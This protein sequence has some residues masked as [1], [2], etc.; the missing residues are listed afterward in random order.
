MTLSRYE[1][2][3]TIEIFKN[4]IEFQTI[5]KKYSITLFDQQYR[6]LAETLLEYKNHIS[7]FTINELNTQ[8]PPF[9]RKEI[10]DIYNLY[11][12]EKDLYFQTIYTF[13]YATVKTFFRD[14]YRLFMPDFDYLQIQNDEKRKVFQEAFMREY[15]RFAYIIDEMYNIVDVD[16]VPDQYLNY[17]AQTVGYE[18]ED[19]K[20]LYNASFRELIKN[21]IEIY[22]IK[23]TNYSFELFFNFLGFEA[24]IK[25]FWFDK[26]FGDPNISVNPY[27]GST[28]QNSHSFYLTTIKPTE[29]IPEGMRNSYIVSNNKIKET[30]DCNEFDRLAGNGFYTYKQ[31]IGDEI[32]YPG[33]P[34]TFFKTNVMEY[35]LLNIKTS[36][37][38]DEELSAEDL[39]TIKR[40]ADFLTPIF[41]KKNIIIKINPFE[42]NAENILFL[43][44]NDRPDPRSNNRYNNDLSTTNNVNDESFLHMY[45]G[46]QPIN[47][48]WED[49][50]RLYKDPIPNNSI[51]R[52][53]GTE[54][55]PGGHFVSGNYNDT[56]EKIWNRIDGN[57]SVYDLIA[58]ENPTWNSEE[59]LSYISNLISSRQLFSKWNGITNL[60]YNVNDRD[61]M[62]PYLEGEFYY[63]WRQDNIYDD[64]NQG[65]PLMMSHSNLESG[66]SFYDGA[67]MRFS[68]NQVPFEWSESQNAAK[69]LNIIADNGDGKAEIKINDTRRRFEF[70]N[71][72]SKGTQN[73]LLQ[74]TF[75]IDSKWVENVEYIAPEWTSGTSYVVGD[76]VREIGENNVFIC[77]QNNTGELL[78]NENYWKFVRG[79]SEI[80]EFYKLY[81]PLQ[82]FEIVEI[83][84]PN[85]KFKLDRNSTISATD[86]EFVFYDFPFVY[87][88]IKD[89]N[90]FYNEGNY[91]IENIDTIRTEQII[92]GRT[93]YIGETILTLNT[94]LNSDQNFEFGFVNLYDEPW[95]MKNF[96]FDFMFNKIHISKEVIGTSMTSYLDELQYYQGNYFNNVVGEINVIEPNTFYSNNYSNY[97]F[98][99]TSQI[100][101]K[102]IN[103]NDYPITGFNDEITFNYQDGSN[104]T[105]PT[106]LETINEIELNE[107]HFGAY[108]NLYKSYET[109]WN[110]EYTFYDNEF[111]IAGLYNDGSEYDK[112]TYKFLEENSN[113]FRDYLEINT[114]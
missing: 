26:R 38:Q 69:I 15:D 49:G 25:E 107:G 31:L 22:G 90:D 87:I 79:I 68:E 104:E 99:G 40:Y 92:N 74:G 44:D 30:L 85:K 65:T 42:E 81:D 72:L 84:G 9:L 47:Y 6:I 43:N 19:S 86:Q 108:Y 61:L 53:S 114:T 59:I 28:D 83:D 82:L 4:D 14:N 94:T 89:T 95:E 101:M 39:E 75:T 45:Q 21:I 3:Q 57:G 96:R 58:N 52:W 11:Y 97:P 113:Y 102:K 32:G 10:S 20:L 73:N 54:L 56:Y 51:E 24:T 106:V 98:T 5:L 27:T 12:I 1:I 35:S 109:L 103:P 66:F 112:N 70:F 71:N 62:Y 111:Q 13:K 88:T 50:T 91:K 18:R 78:S 8:N 100:T 23:G 93:V 2:E 16:K 110:Y 48:Y 41:I 17:L 60:Y 29:Y 63:P 76:R 46:Q 64:F 34:Y 77:I 67:K 80:Q 55:E 33:T 36:E 37:T 7:E 105:V